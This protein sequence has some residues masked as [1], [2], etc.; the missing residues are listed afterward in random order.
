MK[1][2]ESNDVAIALSIS[3][4]RRSDRCIFPQSA[5]AAPM[6]RIRNS[7]KIAFNFSFNANA[8][9]IADAIT[10]AI[11]F[12]SANTITDAIAFAITVKLPADWK[13]GA[14]QTKPAYAG[15]KTLIFH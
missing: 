12:A 8:K 14:I 2:V 15:F 9:T 10:N 1:G 3:S 4:H 5:I 7:A 11:A 6:L 13:S